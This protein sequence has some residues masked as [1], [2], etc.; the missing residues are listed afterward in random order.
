LPRSDFNTPEASRSASLGRCIRSA[1]I[2]LSSAGLLEF[3]RS[4]VG[5][6]RFDIGLDKKQDYTS[7][8]DFLG[9]VNRL[10]IACGMLSGRLTFILCLCAPDFAGIHR[11]AVEKISSA[12]KRAY[13]PVLQLTE[14]AMLGLE[15]KPTLLACA[16]R[17]IWRWK[18]RR[19]CQLDA[20]LIQQVKEHRWKEK[21]TGKIPICR[22]RAQ[23]GLFPRS[24]SSKR[25]PKSSPSE[26]SRSR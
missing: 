17:G 5:G 7:K 14:Y 18:R 3:G 4:G 23:N 6:G 19:L 21:V 25:A 10:P 26:C 8:L 20:A 12:A 22:R 13:L 2:A 1:K 16:H 9:G 11:L 24:G 15:I